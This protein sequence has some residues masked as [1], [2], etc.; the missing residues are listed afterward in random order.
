VAKK[1]CTVKKIADG[2]AEG[3]TNNQDGDATNCKAGAKP[4]TKSTAKDRESGN[5]NDRGDQT[6]VW[7]GPLRETETVK[8]DGPEKKG[9]VTRSIRSA[10][11]G[12][13]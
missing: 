6:L 11:G 13:K 8:K 3:G 1:G 4:A 9:S 2:K 7:G 12:R 10:P 5:E